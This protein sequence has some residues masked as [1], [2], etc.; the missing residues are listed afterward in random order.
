[1]QQTAMHEIRYLA[2]AVES[3]AVDQNSYP[4]SGVGVMKSAGL[5]PI[6]QPSYMRRVPKA[7]PWGE[8]YLYWSNGGYYVIVCQGGDRRGETAYDQSLRTMGRDRPYL[9]SLCTGAT[10]GTAP[11]IIYSQGQFCQWPRGLERP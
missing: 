2:A 10:T 11:D 8:P 7:D 1:M 4:V 5:M 6:L 3:Y 9:G